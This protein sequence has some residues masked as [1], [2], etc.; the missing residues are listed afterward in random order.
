MSDS[1]FGLPR[2]LGDGL[3]LRWATEADADEL[4][5]FNV[6][7]HSDD[8]DEPETWLADWTRELMSGRHPTTG[9]DDFTVVVDENAGGKIVSSLNL[10]SQTWQYEGIPFGCG[11]PELVGT[12]P[13]YRRRGLVRVQMDAVHAKSAARGELVQAITGIP[14]YYRLFE[15]EMALALHG[16]REFFWARPNND[17]SVEDEPYRLRPATAEDIPFLLALYSTFCA[18]SIVTSQRDAATLQWAMLEAYRDAPTPLHLYVIETPEGEGVAYAEYKQWGTGFTVG[19]VGVQPG[20]SWRAVCL[21]LT[22]ELK[23]Q[24]DELNQ[25]RDKPISNITFA[26]QDEH[27]VYQALGW[28]LEKSRKPYAYYIRVPDLAAFLRHIAPA[29]EER[30]ATSVLAGYS[31]VLRLGFYRRH[32][33]LTFEQ[34]KLHEVDAYRAKSPHDADALLPDL[35]FY[36]LLFGYR[37]FEQLHYA[38]ADCYAHNPEA[39]VL[40][41]V[42]FPRRSSHVVP[43]N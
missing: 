5:Q 12:D 43:L 2:K 19:E 4:A 29:L 14:W 10:I 18:D 31:G 21:F 3:L 9:A 15:Y 37:S 11:R 20:H 13:D 6:R 7:I 33:K 40:L 17:K 38:F 39:D 1:T 22:R 25:K 30:L 42:L 27:P 23:R 24:A 8:P 35:T 36:Q 41:N 32:L 34:G 26:L 16:G 28:Q